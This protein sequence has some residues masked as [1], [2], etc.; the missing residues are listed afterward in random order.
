MS[1]NIIRVSEA[2]IEEP[3]YGPSPAGHVV[4]GDPIESLH[5]YFSR[6]GRDVGVWECSPGSMRE[7]Q[8]VDEFCTILAGSF[9]IVDDETGAT[10][11]FQ[12][13]DSF[14][15]PKGSTLTWVIHE[16]V[17]KFYMVVE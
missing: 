15:L 5:A 4:A 11:S 12:A 10:E 14:F 16:T 9:D 1:S 8:I 2:D 3:S 13:G 6:D 17:R 7:P